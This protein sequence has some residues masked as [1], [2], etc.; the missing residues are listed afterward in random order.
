MSVW[1]PYWPCDMARRR[2]RLDAARPIV[3]TRI[4]RQQEVVAARC[5]RASRAGVEPGMTLAHARA[6]LPAARAEA[7]IAPHDVAADLR[8]LRRL[9]ARATRL[10]PIV[11]CDPPDGLLLDARGCERIYGGPASIAARVRAWAMRLGLTAQVAAAPNFRAAWALARFGGAPVSC[12]T[13]A[14]LPGALLALRIAALDPEGETSE[15]LAE[16]GVTRIGELLA[17]PRSG[18]A[19]RCGEAV[20]RTLD[21]ALGVAPEVIDGVRPLAPVTAE[22]EFDGPTDRIESVEACARETLG[23]VMAL[24]RFRECGCRRVVI[25]LDRSDLPPLRFEARATEPTRD[26]KHWWSLLREYVANAHLGFGVEAV[27]CAAGSIARLAHAQ[28]LTTRP[29]TPLC[30]GASVARLA[31]ALVARL[32]GARALTPRI[33][34]SHTPERACALTRWD[35]VRVPL[36]PTPAMVS[37]DRPLLLLDRPV[38]ALVTLLA[39]EGPALQVS[40]RGE[41]LRV[42]ECVG[43]ERIDG[44]WWR[45]DD[46]RR[47]YYALTLESGRRVWVFREWPGDAWFLHGE[48]A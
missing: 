13:H 1:F 43:P 16:V 9:A 23:A 32:G 48:W 17:L 15:R 4:D 38:P 26:E 47:D 19:D 3:L 11:Q 8:S 20:L 18:V 24:L 25:R 30:D 2:W 29:K 28:T 45:G 31:D 10:L 33:V 21:R 39:P 6:L 35:S 5:V 34:E 27:R 22:R 37:A 44:E 12:I 14:D 42:V 36:T 7:C 41:S 40:I 46:A